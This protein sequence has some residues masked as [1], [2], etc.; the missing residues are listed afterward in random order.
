MT[1]DVEVVAGQKMPVLAVS[2]PRV[3]GGMAIAA[4]H[5]FFVGDWLKMV[6]INATLHS[7]EVIEHHPV[8]N[9]A[10]EMLVSPSMCGHTVAFD[11]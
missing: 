1:A 10:D 2:F 8:R 11:A 3:D 7:A 9:G 5:I 6:R 4:Q